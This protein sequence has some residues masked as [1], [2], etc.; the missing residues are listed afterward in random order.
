[1]T[2]A[3]RIQRILD[4]CRGVKSLSGLSSRDETF[5]SDIRARGMTQLSP[6]QEKWVADI[7]QRV[8]GEDDDGK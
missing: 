6:A 3:E 8:F 5:L 1:M 2:V 4:E 7:E